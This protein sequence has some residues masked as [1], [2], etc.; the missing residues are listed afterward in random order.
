VINLIYE[1]GKRKAKDR[2]CMIY[3]IVIAIQEY[4][5]EVNQGTSKFKK[6]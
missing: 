4:L 2:E 6:K 5:E 1:T 3:D